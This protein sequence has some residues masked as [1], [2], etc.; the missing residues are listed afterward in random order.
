MVQN[1]MAR[2]EACLKDCQA[3]HRDYTIG[4]WN[5]RGVQQGGSPECRE[6]R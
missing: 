3:A 6:K 5:Q 2:N 1:T 4:G